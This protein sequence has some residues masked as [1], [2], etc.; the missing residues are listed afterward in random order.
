[1]KLG[2]AQ[3]RTGENLFAFSG[4]QEAWLKEMG[5]H[6]ETQGVHLARPIEAQLRLTK[7]EPD[8][9]LKGVLK[10]E[11]EQ[12]CAR[13]AEDFQMGIEHPFELGLAHV[14]R[15]KETP[16]DALSEESEELDICYFEGPEID[17]APILEEQVLLSLPYTAI[18]KP[19]C[20][21]ICQ[22][23][24]SNL[25]QGACRCPKYNPVSAFSVLAQLKQ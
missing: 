2:L 21:G 25:N 23:C 17:L 24:G 20:K 1:M 16:A 14:T 9:Y 15:G 13:C 12:A 22:T 6:L 11:V 19:D 4:T 7:L 18:C 8:Y 5:N 3:L 10:F